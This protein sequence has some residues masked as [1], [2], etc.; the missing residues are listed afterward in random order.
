MGFVGAVAAGSW[1]MG[2]GII[3]SRAVRGG[4]K[5]AGTGIGRYLK[6][7][8]HSKAMGNTLR[9]FGLARNMSMLGR[10][11]GLG[12]LGFEAIAGYQQE[13]VWGAAKGVASGAMWSYGI[14]LALGSAALPVAA[15]AGIGVGGAMAYKAAAEKGRSTMVKSQN[16]EFGGGVSDQYGTV[17]TMRRRSVQALQQSRIGGG[18]GMGNEALRQYQPYFR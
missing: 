10:G 15:L 7:G 2:K 14:E 9:N 18:M 17:S 8:T 5:Y 1:N 3:G 12:F 13:G 11:L 4:A 6:S 16:L